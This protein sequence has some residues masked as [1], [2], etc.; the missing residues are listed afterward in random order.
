MLVGESSPLV[1]Q[2]TPVEK[3]AAAWAEPNGNQSYLLLAH[4]L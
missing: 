4:V 2:A 3:G 1:N